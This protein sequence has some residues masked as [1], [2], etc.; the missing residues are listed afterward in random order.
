VKKIHDPGFT[1]K[2]KL[3]TPPRKKSIGK[4]NK[5]TITDMSA[6]KKLLRNEMKEGKILSF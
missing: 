1:L 6:I 2:K 5:N 4:K 3:N